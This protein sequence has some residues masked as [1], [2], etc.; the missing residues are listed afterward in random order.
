M[1]FALA[2]HII[3]SNTFI[4]GLPSHCKNLTL[5]L[6]N[7]AFAYQGKSQGTYQI[8]RFVNERPSWIF[9]ENSK[10]IW[11]VPT[12]DDWAIG[13]LKDL[14]AVIRGLRTTSNHGYLNV[15]E[16]PSNKWQYFGKEGWTT[17]N[18]NDVIIQCQGK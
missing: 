3:F 8:F 11:Y 9:K 13:D 10:A 5:T 6:Q 12:Y 1:F 14:G 17:P 7:Y 2:S 18:P 15:F 4:A 16:V